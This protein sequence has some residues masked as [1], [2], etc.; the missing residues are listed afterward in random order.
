MITLIIRGITINSCLNRLFDLLL[1]NRLTSFVNEKS[2][3]KY[4]QIGFR[5]GFHTADHVLTTKTIIDKYLSKNQK[6]YFCF[7][8]FSLGRP[9]IVFFLIGIHS[10]QG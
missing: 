6:L 7:V 10:M 1:A 9:M 2:I 3:L 8:D 5:K 4:N